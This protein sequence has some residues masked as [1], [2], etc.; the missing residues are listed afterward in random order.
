MAVPALVTSSRPSPPTIETDEVTEAVIVRWVGDDER[1]R[2]LEIIAIERPDCRL[3]I[4]VMPTHY[5][6]TR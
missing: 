1:G 2:E 5:R 3:V 4:H 6:R